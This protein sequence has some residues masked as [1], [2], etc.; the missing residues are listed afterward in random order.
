MPAGTR[1]RSITI[2]WGD[3]THAVV[4]AIAASPTH[5][6]AHPGHYTVHVQ[7]TDSAGQSAVSSRAEK[8]V[9]QTVYWDL[10]NGSSLADQ[11][12][13]AKLPLTAKSADTVVSGT[14]DN[15]LRCTAGMTVGPQGHLYVLSYPSGCSAP[16]PAEIEVFAL[17]FTPSS[18]PLF[19]LT[20]PGTGD[21]DALTFDHKGNLWVEDTY[22][23]D[24]YEFAGPFTDNTT[25]VPS[26]TL[27][28]PDM[29]PAGLALDAKGDLFVS[30]A[31][32]TSTRSIA[33]YRAPIT[34]VSV[35]AFLK[36]LASPGG[37][38]FD[39]HGNLYASNN[40]SDG[41][42]AAI[43][44]YAAGHLKAG[45]KP[46]VVDGAGMKGAPYEANFA[47][48]A[49]GNLYVADCGS[50]AN[51]RVYPL[52]TKPFSSKLAPT[53]THRNASLADVGCA[54]GIAIG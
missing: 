33:M 24:V 38:T 45:A 30:N 49:S 19:A 9:T 54:W 26:L 43:V 3:G 35:P 42:G 14:A 29:T 37:L 51:V 41:A 53:V 8:V 11:L 32:S 21:V 4:H 16:F 25:L 27:P 23:K 40:P 48:D 1:L 13:Y 50:A 7:V 44:R 52:A 6:Y 47:W 22:N 46:S 34:D 17:P 15:H 5:R 18:T 12:E 36:G 39:G 31:A 28:L 2:N 10:F 20:L